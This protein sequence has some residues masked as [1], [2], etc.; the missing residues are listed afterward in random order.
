MGFTGADGRAGGSVVAVELDQRGVMEYGKVLMA[1]SRGGWLR[2]FIP[3][4]CL[5]LLEV[6]FS[7]G[8]DV[9][10]PDALEEV[11]V[12]NVVPLKF[13]VSGRHVDVV[14]L[15]NGYGTDEDSPV[16]RTPVPEAWAAGPPDI[17]EFPVGHS[18]D[19]EMVPWED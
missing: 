2:P 6:V 4:L 12:L 13:V 10:P 17:V 1:L 5:V 3:L 11:T 8:G 18:A 19:C 7:R 15:E 16:V 14:M 9:K